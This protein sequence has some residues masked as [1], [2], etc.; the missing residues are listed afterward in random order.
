MSDDN[1]GT[2]IDAAVAELLQKKGTLEMIVEMG[3]HGSQRHTDLRT[4]LLLS[5]STIQQRLKDGKKVGLWEQTLEE[6][7]DIGAKVYQ[8]TPIGISIYE[9][10]VYYDLYQLYRSK[11][12]IMRGIEGLERR[13]IAD[14][15]P[16]DADWLSELSMEEYELHSIQRTLQE[17]T[18]WDLSPR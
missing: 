3:E 15:S 11:R 13:V 7:G 8:L 14:S 4:E 9:N 6:R 10:C 1:G 5:S 16:P 12:G 17:L 2:Q 18:N